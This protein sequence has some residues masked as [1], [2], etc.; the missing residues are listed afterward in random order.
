L[1]RSTFPD[2]FLL[3]SL[4][5]GTPPQ[6]S[7]SMPLR[8]RPF[9]TSR[10]LFVDFVLLLLSV[11][12]GYAEYVVYP[13]IMENVFGETNV[14]LS[15]SFLTFRYTAFRINRTIVGVPAF[16]FFQFFLYAAIVYTVLKYIE[17]RSG[18]R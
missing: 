9:L 3:S 17:Y 11:V 2:E 18:N 10:L 8:K 16:D 13:Q 12:A 1:P 5:E 14:T 6:P 4:P 7:M 15:I